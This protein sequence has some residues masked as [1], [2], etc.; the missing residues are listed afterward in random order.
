MT[1]AIPDSTLLIVLNRTSRSNTI[2]A[3]QQKAANKA[4]ILNMVLDDTMDF[5]L[6]NKIWF[7]EGWNRSLATVIR[8]FPGD[9]NVVR[10]PFNNPG[11]G[12]LYELCNF[13]S[14]YIFGS[15][16]AHASLEPTG[17]LK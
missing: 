13:K 11:V 2:S 10:M 15:A 1:G 8:G 16:V 9:L 17:Q 5:N 7:E 6:R 12:D 3:V 4:L 14:F